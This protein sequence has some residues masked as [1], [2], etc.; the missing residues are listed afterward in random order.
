MA[1]IKMP[2]TQISELEKKIDRII[3]DPK[4]EDL[5]PLKEDVQT[6]IDE[7]KEL[8]LEVIN[9]RSQLEE[10]EETLNAIRT[11]EVDALVI[12]GPKGES[13]YSLAGAEH[14]YRVM[15]ETM[16]E[17]A[18]T[19]TRDGTILFSNQSFARLARLPME[20]IVGT[21]ITQ[22]MDPEYTSEFQSILDRNKSARLE[23]LL[24]SRGKSKIPVYLSISPLKEDSSGFSIV[25]TDLT[26]QKGEEFMRRAKDELEEKVRE[27]TALYAEANKHLINEI[28]GRKR[29]EETLRTAQK[30][31]REMTSAIITAEEKARQNLATNLHDTVV[32]TL[33]AA[34]LRSQ[35]I[36]GDI[37]EKAEPIFSELQNF[38]SESITQARSIMAEMSPSVLNEFGLIS[39]LEW[40]TEQIEYQHGIK[41]KFKTNVK[42]VSLDRE[43]QVLMFQAT[44]E[45]LMNIVK[46]AQAKTA[47]VK[48]FDNGK[49]FSI[50]VKDNG[51]GFD[52]ENTFLPDLKGGFGLYSIRERLR[53]IGGV[54]EIKSNPIKGTTVLITAPREIEK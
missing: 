23:V 54:L 8:E 31:L 18:V 17:G 36:Q 45:L 41:A 15:V 13:V 6:L 2:K 39:A 50:E 42:S 52:V 11:G 38:I 53:H 12:T 19:I 33:G 49:R 44:R 5:N 48:F 47:T 32:Q 1:V 9:L 7:K 20:K 21:N 10:M 22:Y 51:I 46:H 29:T 16:G 34:K 43:V 24:L 37:P 14:P 40:L 25:M 3:S 4:I 28:A 27:R 26:Y 30:N 35:L